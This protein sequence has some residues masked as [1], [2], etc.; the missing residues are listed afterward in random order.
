VAAGSEQRSDHSA[1]SAVERQECF[2][3]FI[4]ESRTAILASFRTA[5]Q[6]SPYWDAADIPQWDQLTAIGSQLITEVAASVLAGQVQSGDRGKLFE[7]APG[8]STSGHLSPTAL[9]GVSVLF[10]H[11]TVSSLAAYVRN[12]AAL[13]PCLT[14][15]VLALHQGLTAWVERATVCHN[16]RLLGQLHQADRDERRRIA[17]ELHDRLGEGLSVAMRQ[18]DL[19][20][21]TA[22]G[23]AGAPGPQMTL[24]REALVESMRRLRAVTSDLHQDR[25][26]SLEKALA[27]Y[28]SSVAAEANVSL[29]VSGDE[30]YAAQAILDEVFLIIREA[31]R[32]ALEHAAPRHVLI[33]VD[34]TPHE[35]RAQ[36]LDNGR[37]F[38]VPGQA[39]V[40]TS[41]T[42]GLASMWERA[43]LLGG[44]L[45][46]AS[47]P[48][49][50]TCVDLFVPLLGR[51]DERSG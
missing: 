24:V 50:G 32:N 29:E 45:T 17:R 37:G 9:R 36:V 48:G 28:L 44:K 13:L 25:V 41:G 7:C 11:A 47:A 20:E 6:A 15:A 26:T 42:V 30:G 19:H 33:I 40:A 23:E 14:T 2:A 49:R 8:D 1:C 4:E 10:F 18:L 46:V 16:T 27:R 51:H 35:L 43:A 31:V 21:I 22:S 5:L 34:V 3:K 12:D 39:D 38:V